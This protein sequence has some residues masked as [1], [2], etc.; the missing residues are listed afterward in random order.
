MVS[1]TEVAI[2]HIQYAVL[3]FIFF[4]IKIIKIVILKAN[5][6]ILT[7]GIYRDFISKIIHL[8]IQFIIYKPVQIE[9]VDNRANILLQVEMYKKNITNYN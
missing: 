2:L 1:N 9:H 3:L 5:M 4:K 6:T 7:V 8:Y